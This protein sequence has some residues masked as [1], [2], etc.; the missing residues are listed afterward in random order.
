ML[1]GL[2][3]ISMSTNLILTGVMGEHPVYGYDFNGVIGYL[4]GEYT[5]I[6]V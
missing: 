4:L 3:R 5:Y 2:D 1:I 6:I